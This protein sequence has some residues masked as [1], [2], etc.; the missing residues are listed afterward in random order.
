MYKN[1]LNRTI[2]FSRMKVF[3]NQARIP[4]SQEKPITNLL[5]TISQKPV[6][7]FAK[8]KN[9]SN[10]QLP[11]SAFILGSEEKIPE[12]NLSSVSTFNRSWLNRFC[13]RVSKN[14]QAKFSSPLPRL[15]FE[16]TLIWEILNMT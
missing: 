16:T 13:I 4:E 8:N 11:N 10:L 3:E 2:T 12:M 6:A 5:V 9:C 14:R 7:D 15:L 1:S